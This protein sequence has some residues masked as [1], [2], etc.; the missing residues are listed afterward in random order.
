MSRK[1]CIDANGRVVYRTEFVAQTNSNGKI[2]TALQQLNII[3]AGGRPSICITRKHLGGIGDVLMMTPTFK[4]LHKEYNADVTVAVDPGYLDGALVKVLT[5]NPYIKNIIDYRDIN[6]ADYSVPIIDLACPC[7]PYETPHHP[8][9]E[10]IDIFAKHAGIVDLKDKHMDYFVQQ[11]ER[12]NLTKWLVANRLKGK[13]LLVVQANSSCARRDYNQYYLQKTLAEI[14]KQKH[15]NLAIVVILHKDGKDRNND[16]NWKQPHLIRFEDRDTR[17][18]GALIEAAEIVLCPD[19]SVL[20]IAG[21][22]DK[23]ILT[24]FGPINPR[25][26]TSYF[27]DCTVIS[28]GETIGCFPCFFNACNNAFTCWKNIKPELVSNVLSTMLTNQPL[29][30]S[31]FIITKRKIENKAGS[32]IEMI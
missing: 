18:I 8:P 28:G 17:D 20:H 5:Y 13:R 30:D 11:S 31:P 2:N 32:K 29:P 27:K 10:R 1:L 23:K 15:K 14:A 16:I 4:A 7:A 3:K 22:L 12:D 26:R 24:L 25:A 19:S 6:T 9:V 21:A